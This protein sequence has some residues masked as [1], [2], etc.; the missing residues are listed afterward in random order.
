MKY[1]C[2][3]Y[4]DEKMRVNMLEREQAALTIQ[5]FYY[6]E[7]L[8][9]MGS[10]L[11]GEEL[12]DSQNTTTVRKQDGKISVTAGP[13]KDTK[14]QF[15]GFILIEAKDLNHAIRLISTH[16][17]LQIGNTWEIR[18]VAHCQSNVTPRFP[19]EKY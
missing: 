16:P 7:E 8:K 4:V 6:V 3:G 1:I 18:P 19:S 15:G 2:L 17:S 10:F 13:H 12:R 11:S 5:Q 14:E 9:R